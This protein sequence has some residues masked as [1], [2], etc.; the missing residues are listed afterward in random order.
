MN[1]ELIELLSCPETGEALEFRD[2]ELYSANTSYPVF[3]NIPWLFKNPEHSYLEWATK[4]EGFI[5][6]ESI[7][8]KHLNSLHDLASD[9]LRKKRYSQLIEA[10]TKN[11][12]VITE[13][14][15]VF[16]GQ[17]HIRL[18]PSNQQIHSYFQLIFRDW[19]WDTTEMKTYIEYINNSIPD[20][21]NKK[22]LILGA[23]A[24]ALGQTLA[25]QHKSAQFIS[26]D[27]NPFLIMMAKKIMNK[28]KVE[29][30]NY[31]FFPKT[32]ELTNTK[33]EIQLPSTVENHHQVLSSF[34]DLPFKENSF[35]LIIAPWFL[36]ILELDFNTA[37]QQCLKYL[38][39]EGHFICIGPSNKHSKD[40]AEQ[41]TAPEMDNILSSNFINSSY[42]VKEIQYLENPIESHKRIEQIILFHG[43]NK[44][45]E[46]Q[47]LKNKDQKKE[48]LLGPELIAFKQKTEI[49]HRIL[50][51]IDKDMDYEQLSKKL[52]VEFNFT[53]DEASFY[54]ESFIKQ[55]QNEI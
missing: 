8:I 49:F 18:M 52:V 35:D 28:E 10:K 31:S 47:K 39:A 42:E 25:H 40:I 50:K 43:E 37:H 34:P 3:E 53:K 30:Y 23:G 21:S 19:V 41:L 51:L 46:I 17:K 15:N 29:L 33:Y 6:E 36:D 2:G 26:T 55:I 27:H 11:L 16:L 9:K 32:L 4:I 5:D 1:Q 22:V 48:I 44:S 14:L 54:A 24:C 13:T 20:F 38:S 12:N 45:S 7:Y